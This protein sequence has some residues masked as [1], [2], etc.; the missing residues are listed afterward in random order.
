MS[1]P[2]RALTLVRHPKWPAYVHEGVPRYEDEGSACEARGAVSVRGGAWWSAALSVPVGAADD[3]LVRLT[4]HG[5]GGQSAAAERI[6]LR[7]S[8]SELDAVIALLAGV[9]A[10]ARRDAV[11]A[12]GAAG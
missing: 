7:V 2:T 11:L 5:A 1:A 4:R 12:H 10:Q 9:V 3:A 6:D 8:A